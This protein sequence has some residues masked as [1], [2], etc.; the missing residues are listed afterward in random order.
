LRTRHSDRISHFFSISDMRHRDTRRT[1]LELPRS[2]VACSTRESTRNHLVVALALERLR[3]PPEAMTRGGA[4]QSGE[5]CQ[6]NWRFLIKWHYTEHVT[7]IGLVAILGWDPNQ[8]LGLGRSTQP[9][10]FNYLWFQEIIER[11]SWCS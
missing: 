2:R 11:T 6:P 4:H 9:F 3:R 10:S 7:C 5:T 1:P 8:A